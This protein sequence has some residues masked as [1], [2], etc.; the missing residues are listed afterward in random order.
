[1]N[2]SQ[3]SEQESR[4]EAKKVLRKKLLEERLPLS[5]KQELAADLRQVLRV[6]GCWGGQTR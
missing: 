6:S 4:I 1:M 5:Q 3:E 2:N